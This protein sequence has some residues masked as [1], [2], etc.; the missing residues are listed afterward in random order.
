M[1]VRVLLVGGGA[2]E[3]AIA[4]ALVEGGA[5]LYAVMKNRNPGIMRAAKDHLLA[6][7]TDIEKVALYAKMRGVELAVV[8]PEAPLEAGVTE[9][10]EAAGVRCASPSRAASRIETSK[11]FMRSLMERHGLPGRVEHEVLTSAAA[12]REFLRD[13]PKGVAVKPVGLTGGKGVRVTGDQLLTRE[14]AIAY[15]TEVLEKK[16]GGEARVV[17]EEKLEG[18]EFTLQAFSD[19]KRVVPMPAV[20]DHK[21]AYE[22]D[23]GPNTGGMGSYSQEDHLLPFMTRREYEEGVRII[24]GIIDA[25]ASEGAPF[26]GPIYGQF[27]LTREGPKVIEV[28][29]RFGDPEAM[30]VLALLETNLLEAC[31][32]MASG[33]LSGARVAFAKKATVCKY[34][35]PKGYGTEPHAGS[36]LL[37]DERG[38]ERDGARLYFASVN[39]K[40]PGRV[41]TT[42][43]RA[44]GVLGAGSTIEEAEAICEA[45]LGRIKGDFFVRHD[46]GTTEAL[47]RKVEHMR[48]LRAL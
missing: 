46:I 5:E 27:M 39:E 41:L 13:Y 25:L 32:A 30:N 20:Q 23:T 47:R 34:V 6:S 38:A 26:R 7:E 22:G 29:A 33:E 16:V 24:Q 40:E 19:G 48:A 21:R 8:G 9:A 37:V 3:H 45:A 14:D 43:S 15:A 18:E 36:E 17:I 1:G 10:L 35:V 2:R 31:E 11:E 4:R 12:V 28:N 42:T 44:I